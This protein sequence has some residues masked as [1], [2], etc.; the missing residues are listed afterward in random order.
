MLQVFHGIAMHDSTEDATV[1]AV[2]DAPKAPPLQAN[3]NDHDENATVAVADI[4]EAVADHQH[5]RSVAAS[6]GEIIGEPSVMRTH[7]THPTT[8][9]LSLIH[10]TLLFASFAPFTCSSRV[11]V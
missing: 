8:L 3:S 9:P 2:S 1:T 7:F 11:H 4:N 10:S 5:T 6:G